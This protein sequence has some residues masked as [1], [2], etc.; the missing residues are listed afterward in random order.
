MKKKILLIL[1]F[2]SFC[3]SAN[4]QGDWKS[5]LIEPDIKVYFPCEPLIIDSTES[6]YFK[7]ECKY[8]DNIFIAESIPFKISFR[9][10]TL[11]EAY[12]KAYEDVITLTK[13]KFNGRILKTSYSTLENHKIIDF[14]IE[15]ELDGK[16]KTQHTRAIIVSHYKDSL[17][18][19]TYIPNESIKNSDFNKFFDS[20]DFF[21]S[22]E[23]K[24]NDNMDPEIKKELIEIMNEDMTPYI[25]IGKIIRVFFILLF[26]FLIVKL[27]IRFKNK[28]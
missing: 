3:L 25:I 8:D 20:V 5:Y 15:I 18:W 17:Y 6:N 10:I 23:K 22:T 19:L 21:V 4:N 13:D 2:L 16:I 28:N 11:K 27:I 12:K 9:G 1:F 7:S 24:I 14:E 26:I